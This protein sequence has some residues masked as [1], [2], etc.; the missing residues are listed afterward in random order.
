M[1]TARTARE[2]FKSVLRGRKIGLPAKNA[3]RI[4][5][6]FHVYNILNPAWYRSRIEQSTLYR[7][8]PQRAILNS[9]KGRCSVTA[10]RVLASVSSTPSGG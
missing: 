9:R 6:G 1:P 2:S 7:L 3:T 5:I 4:L 8:I 10:S